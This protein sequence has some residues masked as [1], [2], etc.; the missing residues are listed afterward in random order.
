[1]FFSNV[2]EQSLLKV[3]GLIPGGQTVSRPPER[4]CFNEIAAVPERIA[5][6]P[7]VAQRERGGCSQTCFGVHGEVGLAL[8]DAVHHPGA[9]PVGGVVR[10]RGGDL[11]H[12]GTWREEGEGLEGFRSAHLHPG[13][14]WWGRA[15]SGGAGLPGD[16]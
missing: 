11:D 7:K 2:L 6:S 4:P 5:N 1:M 9:V 3:G 12:G 14:V 16:V 15:G 8:Q 13:G 10:V